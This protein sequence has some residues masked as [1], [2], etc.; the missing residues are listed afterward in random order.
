MNLET[1]QLFFGYG[2]L[3]GYGVLLLWTAI[4]RFAHD[5]HYKRTRYFFKQVKRDTYDNVHLYGIAAFKLA[6]ILFYVTPFFVL[7]LLRR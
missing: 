6:I 3:I 2:A 4:F 5:W 7:C 1:A